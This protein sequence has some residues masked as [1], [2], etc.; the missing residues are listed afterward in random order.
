MKTFQLASSWDK[1]RLLKSWNLSHF[2]PKQ[3][4][5]RK[6]LIFYVTHSDANSGI[7][8]TQRWNDGIE[9]GYDYEQVGAISAIEI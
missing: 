6:A 5:F 3:V 4:K 8:L 2:L 1:D 7:L 9:Y